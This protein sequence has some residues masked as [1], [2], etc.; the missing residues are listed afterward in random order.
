[1]PGQSITRAGSYPGGKVGW[2]EKRY[3]R[4]RVHRSDHQR[5]PGGVHSAAFHTA[6]TRLYSHSHPNASAF[7]QP[8]PDRETLSH[9]AIIFCSDTHQVRT[10]P[11]GLEVPVLS[12]REIQV[13][14]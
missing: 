6:L 5:L 11:P 8:N 13:Q 7:P 10:H 14:R 2:I 3:F 9:L 12:R 1:M 4:D